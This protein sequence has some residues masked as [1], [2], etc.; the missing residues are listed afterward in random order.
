MVNRPIIYA[1]EQTRSYDFLSLARDVLYSLGEQIGDGL[2]SSIAVVSGLAATADSPADLKV[3]IAAGRIYQI[4]EIDATAYG[5]L[6][7]DTDTTYQQGFAAAQ[8]LTLSTSGL[9]A[10]QSRW[11]LIQAT[12]TQTDAIPSDDPNSGVLNYWN[13]SNP[14]VP[15]VGPGGGGTPQ[16]TSRT[17]VCT[18]SVVY[19]AVATTGS[20]APPNPSS[21]NVPL[22][23]VDLA[24]GQTQITNVEIL[25]AGPSVGTNVP[26]NYPQ[27]PFLA[28]LLS[29]HHDGK[30]GQAPQIDLTK[31]VQG[32]LP[33]THLPGSSANSG[34]GIS[35]CYA[36]AGNPNSH[37]AGNAGSPGVSPPDMCVDTTTGVLFVCTTTGTA[38]TAVWSQTN[39]PFYWGGTSTGSAN[40]Q[41]I[42]P[43]TPA[44]ALFDGM[45]I[46]FIAGYTN[47]SAM[48]VAVS[49][50]TAESLVRY[51]GT[52]TAEDDVIAGALVR[53][54]YHL[55][56]T[57]FYLD[58]VTLP[59]IQSQKTNYAADTGSANAYAS[60]FTPPLAAYVVGMPMRVKIANA[61]N[62][63][64][65]FNGGPGVE[66]VVA[67]DGSALVGTEFG[68]GDL[69]TFMWDGTN[70]QYSVQVRAATD[71][72]TGAGTATNIFVTPKGLKD[73]LASSTPL[74]IKGF[75]HFT[76]NGTTLTIVSSHNVTSF[77]RASAG[78]YSLTPTVATASFVFGGL[79]VSSATARAYG[80][81]QSALLAAGV[82][83]TIY[84]VTGGSLADPAE[85]HIAW[86]DYT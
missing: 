62:G 6:A 86:Y 25:V 26:S 15:L 56:A 3:N 65:T 13:V 66:N 82:A 49:G 34:G 75:V 37:V 81:E 12:F 21:N 19:G 51:D 50:L 74:S 58:S 84:S 10:G 7:Q 55:S 20:E 11:A 40:A 52:A 22:Y 42:A 9:A 76:W 67:P 35:V 78:T 1:Q 2:G 63:A 85:A 79:I 64:S 60:T 46:A 48:T 44:T 47:T 70:I 27:A 72:E 39:A 23:L 32:T 73:H 36:Y 16:N 43:A 45:Q 54:T 57:A 30:A 31:E 41:A 68:A 71:A 59:Q 33:L 53:A 8:T 28:G 83:A 5:T 17:G 77:T 29:A 61:N 69:V 18:L 38:S 14:S 80:F 24:Y 4:A